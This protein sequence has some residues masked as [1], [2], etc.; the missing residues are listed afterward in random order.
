MQLTLPT[1]MNLMH[2]IPFCAR[3]VKKL[4]ILQIVYELISAFERQFLLEYCTQRAKI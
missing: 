1:D 3:R 2:R 4:K